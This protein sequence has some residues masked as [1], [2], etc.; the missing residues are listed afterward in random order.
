MINEIFFSVFFSHPPREKAFFDQGS[1]QGLPLIVVNYAF[2]IP[3]MAG[4]DVT[5]R[6]AV[7]VGQHNVLVSQHHPR[8]FVHH[9]MT[10]LVYVCYTC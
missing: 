10:S 9:R 6:F 3:L 2:V 8:A 4:Y 7:S 5:G 1:I